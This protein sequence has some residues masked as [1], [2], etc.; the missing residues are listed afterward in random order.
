MSPTSNAV[1]VFGVG[2]DDA[3]WT[4]ESKDRAK[5]WGTLISHKGGL[6]SAPA[7]DHEYGY[8]KEKGIRCF[9]TNGSS[10]WSQ[11]Q[12]DGGGDGEFLVLGGKKIT[13]DPSVIGRYVFGHGADDN[14]LWFA[15]TWYGKPDGNW[16]SLGGELKGAPSCIQVGGAWDS[17]FFGDKAPLIECYVVGTDDA[18]WVRASDGVWAKVGGQAIGGVNAFRTDQYE[19]ILAVRGTDST[20][21]LARKTE[22]AVEWKWANYPGKISSVPAC[23]VFGVLLGSSDTA[24]P[25]CFAILPDGQLG[26]L[27]LTGRL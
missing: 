14:A 16:K 15:S 21:W 1:T 2:T 19:T 11:Y 13:S 18:V 10:V 26:F 3:R 7:C 17:A 25:T 4:I 12:E 23:A 27:D 6:F 8:H 24:K 20:L 9:W 22:K 5:T